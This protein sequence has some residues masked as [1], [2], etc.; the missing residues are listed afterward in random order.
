[1]AWQLSCCEV[2]HGTDLPGVVCNATK[3][4]NGVFSHYDIVNTNW[5]ME[6]P[7][8]TPRSNN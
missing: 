7:V 4:R 1:M 2:L 8:I 6:Y 5:L 3:P